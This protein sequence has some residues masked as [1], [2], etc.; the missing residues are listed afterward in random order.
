M[1]YLR[2]ERWLGHTY[3]VTRGVE[4]DSVQIH[5]GQSG[6]YAAQQTCIAE[7]KAEGRS[8][9]RLPI[10]GAPSGG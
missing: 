9:P 8:D 10:A 2:L 6:F 4:E 5:T 3:L 1:G 7:Y